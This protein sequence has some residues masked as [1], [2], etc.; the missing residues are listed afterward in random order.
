MPITVSW[1]DESKQ[2][3]VCCF[4]DPWSINQLIEARKCW[5]RM[6]KSNEGRIPILLDLK[7]THRV[8]EGTLHHFRAIQRTP[9]PRQGE[10]YVTGLNPAYQ[11]LAPYV[12]AADGHTKKKV[13]IVESRDELNLS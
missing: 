6:I 4:E 11:K 5:H 9:H 10:L 7:A 12:F 3:I 13:C 8:P 1:N 2:F